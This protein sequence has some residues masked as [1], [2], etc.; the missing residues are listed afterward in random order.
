MKI[1]R[2]IPPAAALINI[3]DLLH[4]FAGIFLGRRYQ[5]KLENE[6]RE[7]FGT[8]HV[9]LVSSGKAA[10]TI[11]LKALKSLSPKGKSVLIPAYTCFSVPSAVVKAGL[12]VTLCDI[13]QKT[14][15]FDSELFE[16]S[17]SADTL[18][19]V[20]GHLF[21][22]PSNMDRIGEACRK[23]RIFVVEDAAQAMGG[24]YKGNRI[25]TLGD[26]GFFSLGRGKNI[27][28]GSGGIILTNSD[29]IAQKIQEEC[30]QL[31]NPGFVNAITEILKLTMLSVFIFPSLYWFP[32]GLSF[33]RLGQ[34][35]FYRDFPMERLSDMK[36]G[37]LHKWLDRLNKANAQRRSKSDELIRTLRL[38]HLEAGIPYLRLPILANDKKM[39]E[40]F[41]AVSREEG[42]GLTPMYPAPI[43]EIEEIR[44]MFAGQQFQT[45]K[46]VTERLLTIPTHKFLSSREIKKIA[47]MF[48]SYVV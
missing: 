32:A 43:S 45:A 36:A 22:I 20:A 38:K 26:V 44:E 8:K 7:Y 27:T 46:D 30:S 39:K 9:F 17:L 33:L 18:C 1:H 40:R 4:G 14:F 25:G 5:K 11:I 29:I 34:T 12:K 15:D 37:I 13:D 21:G 16:D 41:L 19:V 10:L 42:L 35:F 24:T 48:S 31:R 23:R 3:S 28:C 6:L 47:C 2:T